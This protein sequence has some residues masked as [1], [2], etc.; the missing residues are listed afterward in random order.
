[1]A[2]GRRSAHGRRVTRAGRSEGADQGTRRTRSG[3]TADGRAG[4]KNSEN[5]TLARGQK[6][7]PD[8]GS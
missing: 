1:M 5:W 3:G 4:G 7:I 8:L 6:P 2:A